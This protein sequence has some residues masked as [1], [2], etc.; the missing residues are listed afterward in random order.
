VKVWEDNGDSYA[1]HFNF[2][3]YPKT[4]TI[5]FFDIEKGTAIGLKEWR[6]QLAH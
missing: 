4:F 5:K 6:K 3:V 2:Y 1:T